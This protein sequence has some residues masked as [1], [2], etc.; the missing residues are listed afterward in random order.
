MAQ[1]KA[2]RVI[3]MM[4][5][6]LVEMIYRKTMALEP[7]AIEERTPLTLMSAD[8]ERL[9]TG[10][11]FLHEWWASLV[12]IPLA[13]YLLWRELGVATLGPVGVTLCKCLSPQAYK[14]FSNHSCSM[15][16]WS[17]RHFVNRR[18]ATSR[19]A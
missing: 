11:P 19:L 3:A 2:Y 9:S 12:Q 15:Y 13:L 16:G 18:Q 14:L 17:C 6:S 8:I 7:A 4:R 10:L 1:H 5:G